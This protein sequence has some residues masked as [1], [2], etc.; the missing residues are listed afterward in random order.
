MLYLGLCFY[1]KGHIFKTDPK[2]SILIVTRFWET[3]EMLLTSSRGR[4]QAQVSWGVA[5]EPGCP[6]AVG[7][8]RPA[9]C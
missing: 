3:Q 5:G 1:H 6:P 4:S 9:T 2:F 8:G 7:L